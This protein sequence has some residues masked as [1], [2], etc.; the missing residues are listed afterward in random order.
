[1]LVCQK[2]APDPYNV[3]RLMIPTRTS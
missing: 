1:V 3:A 2:L